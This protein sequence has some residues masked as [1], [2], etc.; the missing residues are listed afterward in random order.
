MTHR[1]AALGSHGR[2]PNNCERDLSKLLQLPVSP[3]WINVPIRD[4][5]DRSSL[6]SSKCPVL[7]PHEV[8]HYLFE[9]W[10][11]LAYLSP[12]NVADDFVQVKAVVN[13]NPGLT[14]SWLIWDVMVDTG[15]CS[16]IPQMFFFITLKIYILP[17]LHRQIIARIVGR[18][19]W[20]RPRFGST[21]NMPTILRILGLC[22]GPTL[23]A[24]MVMIANTQM[25]ARSSSS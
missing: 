20:T 25:L 22:K 15:W 2:Y 6:T 4:P 8:Y 7:L 10:I 19:F 13:A 16:G 23:L 24:F 17:S 21:G 9:T 3:L 5:A 14:T 18:S 12:Q 11:C 1:F